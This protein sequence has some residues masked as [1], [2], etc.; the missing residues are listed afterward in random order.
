MKVSVIIPAFN[1]EET[2]ANVIKVVKKV[3]YVD[4]VIVV[5][6]GSTDRTES[7]A[8]SAGA[9]V[10]NHEVNRV[11]GKLLLLVIKNL[12]VILLHLSMQIFII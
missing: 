8:K 1:E 12:T 9:I 2:V 5:N 3:K 7:E 4:E 10:I 11:R 6:D